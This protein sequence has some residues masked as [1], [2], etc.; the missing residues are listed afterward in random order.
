M[1]SYDAFFMKRCFD[2]ASLGAG[3]TSPNPTVGAVIVHN[4]RIIG[5]GYHRQYGQAHAEVN[6]VNSISPADRPLL[7]HSTIYVSLEPCSIFG[8]TPPCVN[9]IIEKKIPRVVIA[10]LDKTPGVNGLGIQRLKDAGVEVVMDVLKEKGERINSIRNTFVTNDRPYVI[11]KYAQSA[12]GKMANEDRSPV[13]ISNRFA[14]R[15]VHKWRAEIDAIMVGTNTAHYD[16]PKLTNRLY[17]G[18]SPKRVVLDKTLRLSPDLH[19]FDNSTPTFV[20]T[21]IRQKLPRPQNNL[22]Y[23]GVPFDENVLQNC[24]KYLHSQNITSLLVEGGPH[25]LSTFIRH[26]LW[27]EARVFTSQSWLTKG[28]PAPAFAT[29]SFYET[30]IMTD[31]LQYFFNKQSLP[32]ASQ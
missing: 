14:K 16:N 1:K 13:W 21:D 32:I 29:A 5:E 6:A 23:I 31:K 3:Y 20:F 4:Q 7:P 27:D 9:L 8:R 18:H 30:T 12:N 15:L 25:L 2:L 17:F 22:V 11:L 28:I 19:L 10:G 24:L 26:N